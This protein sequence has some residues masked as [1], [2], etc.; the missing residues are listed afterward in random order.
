[1]RHFEYDMSGEEVEAPV[2]ARPELP[3][4]M[5]DEPI[6][7]HGPGTAVAYTAAVELLSDAAKELETLADRARLRETETEALKD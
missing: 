3:S 6:A 7:T 2:K 1:M 4:A 5:A